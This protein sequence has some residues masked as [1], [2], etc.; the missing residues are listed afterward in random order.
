MQCYWN[1]ESFSVLVEDYVDIFK[2]FLLIVI[3]VFFFVTAYLFIL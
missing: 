3:L 1:L 2:C